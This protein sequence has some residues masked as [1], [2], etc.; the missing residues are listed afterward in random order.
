M[1]FSEYPY[2][3]PD[4]EQTEIAYNALLEKCNQS[5]NAEQQA[6]II[7]SIYALHSN[8]SSMAQICGIRHSIDTTDAFYKTEQE[9][10]DNNLPVYE[11]LVNKFYKTILS[12]PFRAELENIFGKQLFRMATLALKI[13]SPDIIEDLVKEN[14]LSTKYQQLM[15][16]AS[17][18]FD[19][20][21]RNLSELAPFMR[22]TNRHIRKTAS[23][24]RWGFLEANSD[25][26]DAI[27][28][29][30]VKTRTLIAKKLGYKNFVQ[31]GYDRMMRTDYDADMVKTYRDA[32]HTYAVPVAKQLRRQ[33]AAR[34]GVDSLKYFDEALVFDSGNA[35]PKGNA[36][37]I[38][39][40]GIRMYEELGDATAE[41]IH[42]MADNQLL[43]LVAK[44]GKAGGGYCTFISNHK[45]P[46]I[47]SNFNGTSSDIDVLTHE[48]GH[49]FQVYCCR[50]FEVSEY[51]WPTSDAA[52]IH[53]MSMEYFTY[54][55]MDL[56]FAEQADKYR[57]AHLAD[58]VLFLPYGVSV[59]EFQHVVYTHYD[60]TP[61]ERKAA[62]REI[63][64]KYL[65]LREYEENPY[66][67]SGGWWQTQAHIFQSP[68]YYIDY[69]LAQICAFQF[70]KKARENHDA[71]FADYLKLCRAGGS[72]SFLELVELADLQSPFKAG[73][74]RDV[75]QDVTQWLNAVNADAYNVP[76]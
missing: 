67:E 58:A 22:S 54:P 27:F 29:E 41:F 68:F 14:T 3:R 1:T 69:T 47:F 4:L 74:L 59:D 21:E 39:Q 63:E 70:W 50:N 72:K 23:E 62:W 43:D 34:L 20:K 55:W 37:W 36:D 13:F 9:Y 31:L 33:Q 73:V 2:Q 64:K 32:V 52:E 61:A 38:M 19:G 26:L 11:K 15:A 42:F 56:F 71:A 16:S 48:V 53:S 12:S 24:A 35:K 66:L 76:A 18:L 5:E 65:P 75:M 28:D 17:I 10:F 40:N 30:M 46:F 51:Y 25:T 44:K 8:F 7:R 6:E 60:M 49:A 45:S 57:Y